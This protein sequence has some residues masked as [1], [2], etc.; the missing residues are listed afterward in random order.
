MNNRLWNCQ[1]QYKILETSAPVAY[2]WCTMTSYVFECDTITISLQKYKDKSKLGLRRL[3]LSHRRLN[4]L[5]DIT[6]SQHSDNYGIGVMSQLRPQ[7]VHIYTGHLSE[8]KQSHVSTQLNV[9][10][11]KSF[12]FWPAVAT[13]FFFAFF[14]KSPRRSAHTVHRQRLLEVTSKCKVN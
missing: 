8:H 14:K 6:I 2:Q 11:A 13:R 12:H 7:P 3:W 1:F 5:L 9:S 4:P 10:Q